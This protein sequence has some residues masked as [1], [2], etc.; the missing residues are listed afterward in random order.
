MA[1]TIVPKAREIMPR[2]AMVNGA[3]PFTIKVAG[4]DPTPMNTRNAV[5]MASAASFWTVVVSSSMSTPIVLVSLERH[6]I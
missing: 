5:P 4:T 2:S 1:I 6:S 3:S